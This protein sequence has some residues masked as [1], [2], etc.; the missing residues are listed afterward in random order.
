M[1]PHD[2]FDSPAFVWC[3]PA[4]GDGRDRGSVQGGPVVQLSS[5]KRMLMAA[6][7]PG[8]EGVLIPI[9]TSCGES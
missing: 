3:L 9:G 7:T 4:H 2:D 1:T 5:L 6:D 8:R